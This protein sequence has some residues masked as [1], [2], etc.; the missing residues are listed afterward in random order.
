MGELVVVLVE[1]KIQGN[2]G[3]VARAMMNFGVEHLR[4]VTDTPISQEAR[5]RAVHAQ[6]VLDNAV[7]FTRF[8]DAVKDV[9]LRVATT[10]IVPDNQKRHLRS[11]LELGEFAERAD[12]WEG[13]IGLIFGREDYGLLNPEIELCDL[14]VTVPTSR[15]Y[16]IMNLS[17]AVS[18][19]LYHLFI[20][21]RRREGESRERRDASVE[22][23]ERLF[24]RLENLLERIGYP[25]HKRA[26]TAVMFRRILGR[27][28]VSRWEFH[29]LMGVVSRIERAVGNE[30]AREGRAVGN[31]GAGDR[32]GMKGGEEKYEEGGAQERNE[33]GLR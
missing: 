11:H 8:V 30:K 10:G 15:E 19:V 29:T 27:A 24:V 5:N 7:L 13:R 26:N 31:E 2:I 25:E 4:L 14:V 6:E 22:D 18:T 3:A 9:D 28:F 1:P 32:G 20:E 16:P 33:G 23:R 17:H 21:K 12:E